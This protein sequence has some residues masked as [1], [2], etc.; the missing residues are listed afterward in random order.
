MSSNTPLLIHIHSDQRS[1]FFDWK[2]R[3]CHNSRVNFLQKTEF[4]FK[5][6]WH[7]WNLLEL[8]CTFSKGQLISKASFKFSL[9]PKMSQKIWRISALRVFTVFI[10]QKSFKFFGSFLGQ[11]K[12]L[13]FA[14]EINWPLEATIHTKV[15]DIWIPFEILLS[16]RAQISSSKRPR[17]RLQIGKFSPDH[18]MM[19]WIKSCM[20]V[21]ML[22]KSSN[23][24][25]NR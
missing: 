5:V 3:R 11:M 18:F 2:F 17:P 13:K 20:C 4:F 15:Y 19:K 23:C 14:F 7:L 8:T 21:P 1:C 16:N 12:T 9:E 22:L 10:G 24:N 6:L 25:L